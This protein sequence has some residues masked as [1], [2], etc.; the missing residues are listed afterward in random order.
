MSK[1]ADLT[2]EFMEIITYDDTS[3]I[4]E[5]L[6]T[7][8]SI[9]IIYDGYQKVINFIESVLPIINDEDIKQYVEKELEK[10]KMC[11]N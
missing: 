7:L 8:F 4:I 3:I 1:I 5:K 2:I 10:Y 9:M 6:E 11:V